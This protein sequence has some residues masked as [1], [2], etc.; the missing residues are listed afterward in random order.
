MG[1]NAHTE[2]PAG[3]SSGDDTPEGVPHSVDG[4]TL[5]S[6]QDHRTHSRM[7]GSAVSYRFC[8][9]HVLALWLHQ[10]STLRIEVPRCVLSL[11][12]PWSSSYRGDSCGRWRIHVPPE[13]SC[14]TPKFT[15]TAPLLYRDILLWLLGLYSNGTVCNS[16]YD[17]HLDDAISNGSL[18]SG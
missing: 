8:H 3:L 16:R 6:V 14:V 11:L 7:S 17:C 5:S 9:G 10:S 13:D 12:L 18:E 4:S 15:P 2:T 1:R